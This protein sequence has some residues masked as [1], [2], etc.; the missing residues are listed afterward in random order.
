MRFLSLLLLLICTNASGEIELLIVGGQNQPIKFMAL[1][2]EYQG[3]GLNPAVTVE[4]HIV[5]ALSST[6]LFTMPLRYEKPQNEANMLAWQFA[7]IRYVL[8]GEIRE[9]EETIHLK[10]T[11]NDTLLLKP[12]LSTVILNPKELELSSQLFA[13]QV[14]RSM[15]YTTFTNDEDKQ[16][17]HNE[18]PTFTR[19]LNQLV[20]LFKGA[21]KSQ[22]N[23]GTCSVEIQQMPGGV[24]FKS[25]LQED[26]F[27]DSQLAKEIQEAL[28]TVSTLPYEKYQQVF[29]KY[30]KLQ[31][32][33]TD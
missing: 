14:Y 23:R 7:G 15:F 31:F 6:G 9:L 24:P 12:T 29:D 2:F 19:Y 18:D 25:Q 21:W 13:D 30:L 16:Y 5:Q 4:N 28:D 26:C 33:S 27:N 8:Q 10:L 1:P 11:I 20:V 3:D 22:L 17:L 32:I